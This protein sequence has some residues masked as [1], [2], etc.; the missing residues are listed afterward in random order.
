MPTQ[1]ALR[2]GVLGV[3][4]QSG[5]AHPRYLGVRLQV[6]R[7]GQCIGV[8][9]FHA[10]GQGLDALQDQERIERRQR[11]AGIPQRHH[12]R[13]ADVGRWPQ[14]FGIDHAMV[15]GVGL[16]EPRE[17][18]GLC[19]PVEAARID[20][21]AAQAG[22]V[23]AQVLGQRVHHDVGAVLERAQQEGRGHRI[24]DDQRHPGGMRDLGDGGDV[25][26]VATRVADGFDEHRLG[27]LVDHRGE[28][29]RI[30]RISKARL[31]A[32]LRQR[33]RQQ[34]EAAA[35][36]RAGGDD[37]V[38]GLCNGL[39]GIGDRGLPRGQRQRTDA[40][41]QRSQALLQYVGGGVHD[42]RIDIARYLQVEKVG[43]VL[44][45]I[46]GIRHRLVD[47]H[48]HRAGSRVGTVAAVHGQ[49]FQLPLR[50]AHCARLHPGKPP[51]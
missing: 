42:A 13:A 40:A 45:V 21:R 9:A 29:R 20:D 16:V 41:F 44:G 46:E 31:D 35:I 22:A 39:D 32:V 4:G 36:Q 12:P 19:G 37:V 23:A 43:T 5:V 1:I 48:R 26:D 24:V 2:G 3:V 11:S 34:V 15:A 51:P 33:V 49:G 30:S 38:A 28:R 6:L 10:Q 14:G 27:A 47:R 18:L 25:G 7:D 50:I 8:D 17:A